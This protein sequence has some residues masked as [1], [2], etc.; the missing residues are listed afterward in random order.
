MSSPLKDIAIY[1]LQRVDKALERLNGAVA[2]L[3]AAVEAKG[4]V[5]SSHQGG[6]DKALAEAQTELVTLRKDYDAIHGAASKVAER[7]DG[8][9]ERLS[10][11]SGSAAAG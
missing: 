10:S 11:A 1:R 4:T 8:T 7:L 9:L 3:E 5:S 2:R 6:D